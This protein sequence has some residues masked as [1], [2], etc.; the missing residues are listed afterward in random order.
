MGLDDSHKNPSS[1]IGSVDIETPYDTLFPDVNDSSVQFYLD[2][3][4]IYLGIC[5]GSV[6]ME[7]ALIAVEHLKTNP[8][9]VAY[10]TN[11]TLVP[12]NESFKNKVLENLKTLS[13]FNLLTRDSVRSAYTFA[14]LIEEAPITKTD[15]DV[16]KVLTINP[17]ISLVKTSE[18]LDMA[19]RTV[20]RSLERL[21]ERHFVRF[22]AILDYTAFNIQSAMLFFTVK[23]DVEWTEVEQG[24]S[25]YPFTKSFLKTT[26]TDLGYASFMIPN[27]ERNL[28]TFHDSIR[29]VSKTY[30]DYSSLHYQTGSGARSNLP[31][32]ESGKWALASAVE[33]PF[34][35][36]TH[37]IDELPVL[38]L[39]KGIQ[40][41]FG[42][43]ELA[44][45]NQLQID[46][47]FQPSK[48]SK[49]L[50]AYGWDIDARRVSQVIHK[51]NNRALILPYVA[52]SGLGLTSNFC[53]EIVCNDSWRDRILSTIVT[54]PWTMYY[55]SARGIIVWTSVPANQQVE[56][57]QVFRALQQMSGVD[58]VQPI[59]TI[60]QRGSR[61][62][63]D[64]TKN[65]EYYEG[66]WS[67][68]PD[69]VDIR[70][71]LPP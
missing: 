12:I 34:K 22:S 3:M 35:E 42:E 15:L 18:I 16:L 30:F 47:R 50:A 49:N 44:V 33:S 61:A 4:R 13:K 58:I 11:P 10:P 40:S 1:K 64:L 43:T 62:T 71:Y 31:L 24:F 25:E 29:D 55:L 14:F 41:E 60:S 37:E 21:R 36:T 54:F 9:F 57:Y 53:F 46:V 20:A 26:M 38:L 39:C 23:E 28:P 52:V 68:K 17:I 56:Y 19:P 5:S 2:A 32:F 7:D 45:G 70:Q 65:W 27:R 6:T 8:E 48:I 67:V 59:M 51:L 66:V 69:E 63:M